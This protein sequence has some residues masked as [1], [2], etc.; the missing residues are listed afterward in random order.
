MNEDDH[1]AW[2]LHQDGASWEKIGAELE[3]T[4]TYAQALASAY[5]KRTDIA[6]SETQARLF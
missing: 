5:V 2:K 4:P 1:L 6:A 3:C